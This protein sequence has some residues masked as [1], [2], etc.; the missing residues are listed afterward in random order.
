[1]LD[2]S[3]RLGWSVIFVLS[4]AGLSAC[5]GGSS[6]APS[7]PIQPSLIPDPVPVLKVA[8]S[9]V[10]IPQA[11]FAKLIFTDE[12]NQIR[13][14]DSGL[15]S[16]GSIV[17]IGDRIVKIVSKSVSILGTHYVWEFPTLDEAYDEIDVSVSVLE[18]AAPVA[19][20]TKH[21][22]ATGFD[23]KPT[24]VGAPPNA[25]GLRVDCNAP[26][27]GKSS[28]AVSATAKIKYEGIKIIKTGKGSP[29]T[30]EWKMTLQVEPDVGLRW[31]ANDSLKTTAADAIMK[32]I[33]ECA[34]AGVLSIL[35]RPLSTPP[36]W[37]KPIGSLP[38]ATSGILTLSVPA[39]ILVD[40][41]DSKIGLDIIG[42][43]KWK[44]SAVKIKD[45]E[46]PTISSDFQAEIAKA[47]ADSVI[48]LNASAV[49]KARLELT[50]MLHFGPIP[51]SGL[52]LSPG[53]NI[54]ATAKA[55]PLKQGVCASVTFNSDVE[56]WLPGL[57]RTKVTPP[58][59]ISLVSDK[60]LVGDTC[61]PKEVTPVPP[62]ASLA[63]DASFEPYLNSLPLFGSQELRNTV[64]GARAD[65]AQLV[66]NLEA[67]PATIAQ[68]I[69]A[70]DQQL[71]EYR[72]IQS[73]AETVYLQV[74]NGGQV[75]QLCN[76]SAVAQS[77]SGTIDSVAIAWGTL[78]IGIGLNT[79]GMNRLQCKQS[80][81]TYQPKPIEPYCPY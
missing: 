53:I 11:A 63:C 6:E 2:I 12:T 50:P 13:T 9:V 45:V 15:L 38:L 44:L 64:I 22:L 43:G 47:A 66:T 19:V 7:P 31:T 79:W 10:V 29:S 67:S 69:T 33:P 81:G 76:A 4:L 17:Q 30:Q 73:A 34:A 26:I 42:K 68:Y 59:E 80:G 54:K 71:A 72:S 61:D 41:G 23:C 46:L 40:A 24:L 60:L 36:A 16:V 35:G 70:V 8:S 39:C 57:L 25:G 78:R 32:T 51:V 77:S 28:F 18:A 65:A 62:P 55:T 74:S 27:A 75:D 56:Y 49:L 48:G 52:Y 21:A 3:H 58:L 14:T 5:G 1:M 20:S 37:R